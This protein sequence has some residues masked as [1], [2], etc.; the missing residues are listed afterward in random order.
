MRG[1]R[2]AL[3]FVVVAFLAGFLGD[4]YLIPQLRWWQYARAEPDAAANIDLVA[5]LIAAEAQGEPY[6]GQVGVGA[7]IMNRIRDP[8]FPGTIPG[9]IYQPWA[10]ESVGIGLI[11]QRTPTWTQRRA[12]I[13][14]VSGWDPTYGSRFFW[15]PSKPVS[16]WIWTRQIVRQ[17]GNH[18]F[19]L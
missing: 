16:P 2:C 10:F 5:R 12:A 18:V 7:V 13:D 9:V 11:W 15:N 19:A 6:E 1:A 4:N 17:I 3:I 8:K 14:A